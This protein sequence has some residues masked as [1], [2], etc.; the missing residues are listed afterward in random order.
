MMNVKAVACDMNASYE[1]AFLDKYP[2]IK[3]VF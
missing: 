1:S 3:I 2:H